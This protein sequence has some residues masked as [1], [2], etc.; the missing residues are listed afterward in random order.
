[1]IL[2]LCIVRSVQGDHIAVQLDN[3][4]SD[5][6]VHIISRHFLPN[7]GLSSF[8]YAA[9]RPVA[10]VDQYELFW[11]DSQYL[12]SKKVRKRST[13]PLFVHVVL[14]LTCA[15]LHNVF[16][17]LLL[18]CF[19]DLFLCVLECEMACIGER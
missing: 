4:S 13:L 14:W 17:L 18:F 12:D 5:V 15:A 11:Q 2:Y 9:S 16:V 3:I 8:A 1:M 6:R 19:P 10:L 7:A